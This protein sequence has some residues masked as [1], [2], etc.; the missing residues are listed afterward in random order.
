M[1]CALCGVCGCT[2]RS[3]VSV[4]FPFFSFCAKGRVE[5]TTAWTGSFGRKWKGVGDQGAKE[6]CRSRRLE[7]SPKGG[8]G[9]CCSEWGCTGITKQKLMIT[10]YQSKAER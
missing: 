5:A 7:R 8:S 3:V 10:G 1:Q 9:A 4:P 2:G 6:N